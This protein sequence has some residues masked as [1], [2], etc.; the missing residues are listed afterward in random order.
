M[1]ILM[2]AFQTAKQLYGHERYHFFLRKGWWPQYEHQHTHAHQLQRYTNTLG[3]AQN[4]TETDSI[5][6]A[7]PY[8]LWGEGNRR[9]LK[10]VI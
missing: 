9:T 2:R 7:L 5:S 10:E 3:T 1:L 6:I 4:Q 8:P